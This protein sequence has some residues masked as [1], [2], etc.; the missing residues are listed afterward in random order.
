MTDWIAQHWSSLAERVDRACSRAGRPSGSVR[1]VAVSKTHP[2]EAVIAAY[3]AGARIFGENYAQEA[4]PKI[5]K[6]RSRAP[7]AEWHFVGALQSNK[8]KQVVG[9][10][11]LL[12]SLD[13]WSLAEAL[14]KERRRTGGV[15][16]KA[17]IEVNVAQELSKSGVAPSEL[18]S[19][20]ERISE[21]TELQ[22]MG[23]MVFPPFTSDPEKSRKYFEAA[24]KQ[25][26]EVASWKLPRVEMT[27]LSMGVTSDFEVAV[28]EGATLIRIGTAIFG[29]RS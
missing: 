19:L 17:L 25:A 24:R 3:E 26:E 13:R 22:V 10:F 16:V 15:H 9:R 8:A 27:E 20:V 21:R 4:L 5:E 14:E 1:I 11:S 29:S 23:L 28:E 6:V 7:D 2:P 12:H 18:R